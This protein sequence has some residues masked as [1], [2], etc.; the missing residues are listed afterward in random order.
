MAAADDPPLV[1]SGDFTPGVAAGVMTEVPDKA[2]WITKHSTGKSLLGRRNWQ[3]RYLVCNI[4]G[5]SYYDKEPF[6][7]PKGF[8]AWDDVT[9]VYAVINSAIE[10]AANDPEM[11]YFGV[12]FLF[13]TD[14]HLLVMR[15][16]SSDERTAWVNHFRLMREE[17]TRVNALLDDDDDG[18]TAPCSKAKRRQSKKR[19]V[20]FEALSVKLRTMVSL[21]KQRFVKDGIDLDLAYITPRLIAMGFPSEGREA[22]FRNP[23][24][25]VL[26][27]FSKYH[28][29]HYKVYNLCSE[30]CY[31]PSRF[32]GAFERFPFDDH[33]PPP[34]ALIRPFCES[35]DKFLAADAKNV[36][37]VHCKAGKGRTGLMICAYLL[38]SQ[39][40]GTAQEALKLFGDKRT[41]DGKGVQIPSQK[42]YLRYFEE[43]LRTYKGALPPTPRIV[44]TKIVLSTTPR[45]D[46]DGGCDPYLVVSTR[47]PNHRHVPLG[48]AETLVK[49]SL[50]KVYDSH[51]ALPPEHI[52][53]LN[54]YAMKLPGR[55]EL[56]GEVKLT[57]WD[58][59]SLSKDDTMCS[60]WLHTG[61]LPLQ[62]SVTLTKEQLDEAVKDKGCDMFDADF[63]LT[64]HYTFVGRDGAQQ[65]QGGGKATTPPPPAQATPAT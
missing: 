45:F 11:S 58:R 24:P 22:M 20:L 49:D 56:S 8:I 59:D 65:Q 46:P 39:Q 16:E 6:E 1:T 32:S 9:H 21:K 26:S 31:P 17:A 23:M 36:I 48:V 57:L 5:L 3:C 30:R 19:G 44:L 7:V 34:L 15:S 61:F 33:N 42:R 50:E 14:E 55:C 54:N 52:V 64:V 41:M 60:F 12:R 38:W 28:A 13:G 53:K 18:A 4:E 10:P 63:R 35:V 25:E 2:G 40:C 37:A 51:E 27:F 47:S 29:D 43:A 62:G